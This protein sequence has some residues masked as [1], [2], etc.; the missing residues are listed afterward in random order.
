MIGSFARDSANKKTIRITNP[1]TM[2]PPTSGSVQLASWPELFTFPLL[3]SPSM[4]GTT[5]A[6]N[7]TMPR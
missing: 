6:V 7:R 4:K 2:S 3:V 1:M 5:P